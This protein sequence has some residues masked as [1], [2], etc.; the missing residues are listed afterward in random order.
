MIKLNPLA[1]PKERRM[2]LRRFTIYYKEIIDGVEKTRIKDMVFEGEERRS[3]YPEQPE[4]I[5][6]EY[7]ELSKEE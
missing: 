2:E 4:Y 3:I 1:E 6:L 5:R 7:E